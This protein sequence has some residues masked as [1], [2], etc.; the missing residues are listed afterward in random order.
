MPPL[1]RQGA[2]E[3]TNMTELVLKAYTQTIDQE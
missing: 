1:C 3:S 2:D